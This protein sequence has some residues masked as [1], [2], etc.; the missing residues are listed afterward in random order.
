MT[1]HE[2][3]QE[4]FLASHDLFLQQG[5]EI[6]TIRQISEKAS[7]SLGLTNHFFQSKI[8]LAGSVL[9]ML[10]QYTRCYCDTHCPQCTREPLLYTSVCTRVNTL[11]LSQGKYGKFYLDCLKYDIFFQTIERSPNSSLYSLAEKYG[12][13]V[14]DDL[15]TLYGKYV[16]YNYEKTLILNK[17]AGLFPS[18]RYDDIPDYIINSKFEHF[19]DHE[20]LK[21]TLARARAFADSL[22]DHMEEPVPRSFIL[23]YLSSSQHFPV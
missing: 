22:L 15:F 16:P 5:Y 8:A 7:V 11:F 9:E 6:T 1:K 10:F 3:F 21:E 18:I 4:I 2:R 17:Q 14:D 19:L 20:I 23:D 12:F 13:P